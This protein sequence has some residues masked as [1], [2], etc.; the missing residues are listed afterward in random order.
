VIGA[1]VGLLD[2]S[3]SDSG[4]SA[5]GDAR[6]IDLARVQITFAGGAALAS[7]SGMVQEA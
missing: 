3:V 6:G 5:P 2:L 1:Y 7:S 4:V